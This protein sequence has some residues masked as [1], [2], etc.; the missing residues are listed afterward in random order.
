M[1]ISVGCAMDLNGYGQQQKNSIPA[2]F[3]KKL[4]FLFS[5]SKILALVELYKFQDLL[6]ITEMKD[7]NAQWTVFEGQ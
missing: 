3:A 2:S 1:T 5:L 6:L 7:G 4:E